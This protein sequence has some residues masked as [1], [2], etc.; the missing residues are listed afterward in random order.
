M[1]ISDGVMRRGGSATPSSALTVQTADLGDLPSNGVLDGLESCVSF[2]EEE[3]FWEIMRCL[4]QG[5]VQGS[6]TGLPANLGRFD[7][8]RPVYLRGMYS[9][10]DVHLPCQTWTGEWRRK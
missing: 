7:L 10:R 2:T 5:E 8:P 1:G 4:R 6:G 9:F 3:L